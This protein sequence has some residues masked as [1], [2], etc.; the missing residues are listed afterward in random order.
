MYAGL[1]SLPAK[2]PSC[3]AGGPV[4]YFVRKNQ[5]YFGGS[6]ADVYNEF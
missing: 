4:V 1:L 6:G 2:G 5:I 3:V